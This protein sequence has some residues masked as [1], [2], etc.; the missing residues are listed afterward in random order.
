MGTNCAPLLAD[1][2]LYSYEA[3]FIQKTLRDKNRKQSS[4]NF[5][6]RYIDDVLSLNNK[7]FH[8]Y[9]DFIYPE[10]LQIK[11]T[12][13]ANNF[14]TYLDLHLEFDNKQQLFTKLYDK[15][16]DFNF[17]IVNFPY[18]SSN[19]P[20]AP[21]YGVFVSQLIRYARANTFY[22]DFVHRCRQLVTRLV[23]QGYTSAKLISTFGKFYGHHRDLLMKY[24]IPM[25]HMASDMF[26][27]ENSRVVTGA[28]CGAGNAH[29]FRNT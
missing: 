26:D 10:E 16:D 5:T 6:F 2:F 18:I 22:H 19:I 29:S 17:A 27:S 12:T 9:L 3:E 14:A 20:E 28:T 24:D 8:E 15:R 21:A 23:L 1:L 4:F 13:D 7:T 25:S 11:D